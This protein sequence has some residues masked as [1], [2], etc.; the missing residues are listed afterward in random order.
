MRA[1]LDALYPWP[2][3]EALARPL[4]T[5]LL[6]LLVPIASARILA[7]LAIA[8]APASE[9]PHALAAR[10]A[11]F[12]TAAMVV[13]VVQLQL[14][15]IAGSTALGPAWVHSPSAVWTELFAALTT[16]VAFVG[17]GIGRLVEREHSG[18]GA[19]GRE[20]IRDV[21][22]LRLRMGTYLLGPVALIHVASALPLL[23]AAGAVQW[24]VLLGAVAIVALGVAYG[25][26]AALIVTGAVRR[27]SARIVAL[28]QNAARR[29]GVRLASVWRLPTGS[30]PFANAAA[31]P[32]A[33]TMVV[34]DRI[35]EILEEDELDAVLAHEAGHLSET[36]W[37]GLARVGTAVVLVVGL[38]LGPTL[39]WAAGAS[40]TEQLLALVTL[41]LL[42][43]L[44]LLAVMR[45]AR[46]MEERA[47]AHA[48]EHVGADALAR[49]LEKLH[50]DALAPI[51]TGRKRVHPDLFDRLA[52]CGR[53]PGPR[54]APPRTRMGLLV[55]L[56][57]AAS[58]IVG[59]WLA[60]QLT[61]LPASEAELA[62]D[63]ER[64][65]RRR[66]DPWDGGAT[67]ALA[68]QA[69][70]REDLERAEAYATEAAHL[71]VASPALLEME[72]ELLAARGDCARAEETFDRALAARVVDPLE[73]TLELGGYR[74]PPTLMTEC[75]M[76]DPRD[77]SE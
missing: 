38:T 42:G 61:S 20:A 26:L 48:R 75:G 69:R 59:T 34:T 58:M 68:W 17:G 18:R 1:L 9:E 40:E 35:T 10:L 39:L 52:A 16:L 43:L 28:A 63:G 33:R 27:P 21:A 71:G 12:R 60:W 53:E 62:S 73:A 56:G 55:G 32:W 11:P 37:V 24:G 46:R 29:E 14:A 65:R 77:R 23:D 67:L 54:P 66:V 41:A 22:L 4:V 19:S 70:R 47:D 51:V 57:V 8:R 64:W 49:A 45:L 25:G 13:G 72:A 6:A 3:E 5:L 36:P 74:I 31:I 15:W 76:G 50:G 44:V 7:L 2:L 30:V